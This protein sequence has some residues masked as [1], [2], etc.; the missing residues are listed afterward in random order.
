LSEARIPFLLKPRRA[1]K[2]GCR[3]TQEKRPRSAN[4]S[5]LV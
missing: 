5:T 4:R 1:D 3:A 2:I